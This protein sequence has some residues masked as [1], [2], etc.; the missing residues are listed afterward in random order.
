MTVNR[1]AQITLPV[2]VASFAAPLGVPG[3]FWA[4]AVLLRGAIAEETL[5]TVVVRRSWEPR[6]TN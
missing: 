5:L 4:K 3:I 1:L 2:A 6:S